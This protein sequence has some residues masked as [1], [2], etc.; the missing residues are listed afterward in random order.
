MY[1][2]YSH[3]IIY[4]I[5]A[6]KGIPNEREKHRYG[7]TPLPPYVLPSIDAA[8]QMYLEQGGNLRA[9]SVY[10]RDPLRNRQDLMLRRDGLFH[11]RN[12]SWEEIFSSVINGDGLRL[13]EAI[14]SFIN[15]TKSFEQFL[16]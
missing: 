5:H 15:I 4:T 9:F 14:L 16:N 6:G 10:G 8:R 11:E 2:L 7:V 12:A 1:S 3:A 13:K